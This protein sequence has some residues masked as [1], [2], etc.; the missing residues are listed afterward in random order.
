[1]SKKKILWDNWEAHKFHLAY[2]RTKTVINNLKEFHEYFLAKR[3]S[4]EFVLNQIIPDSNEPRIVSD[5]ILSFELY[6]YCKIAPKETEEILQNFDFLSI[7]SKANHFPGVQINILIY[8]PDL[9][10]LENIFTRL[11]SKTFFGRLE[12]RIAH[13]PFPDTNWDIIASLLQKNPLRI[14]CLRLQS[15]RE[16]NVDL[17]PIINILPLL[18]NLRN[19]LIVDFYL[20]DLPSF[21]NALVAILEKNQNFRELSVGIY[22]PDELFLKVGNAI[23]MRPYKLASIALHPAF[24]GR[25]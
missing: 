2:D 4:L 10:A 7:F 22:L 16:N 13:S 15:Y 5:I 14:K 12:I 1:M 24:M 23:K 11:T 19:F 8:K 25:E 21:A 6:A 17:S 20:S 9:Q 3:N 18:K